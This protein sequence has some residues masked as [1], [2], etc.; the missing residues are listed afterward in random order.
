MRVEIDNDVL[1]EK[2][3]EIA[4]SK[5]DPEWPNHIIAARKAIENE[6]PPLRK[7]VKNIDAIEV[8]LRK[9]AMVAS[10]ERTMPGKGSILAKRRQM[11]ADVDLGD[12]RTANVINDRTNGAIVIAGVAVRNEDVDDDLLSGFWHCAA[13]LDAALDAEITHAARIEIGRLVR[14]IMSRD[15]YLGAT[16]RER[17]RVY[18]TGNDTEATAGRSKGNN[19]NVERTDPKRSRANIY[20]DADSSVRRR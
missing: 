5:N 8:D 20:G 15:K 14:A 6:P 18:G 11:I 16:V 10:F 19:V 13:Q 4:A 12:G 7:L 2:A 17:F 3:M 9:K 1:V